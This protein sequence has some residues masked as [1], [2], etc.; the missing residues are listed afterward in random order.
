MFWSRPLL[1]RVPSNERSGIQAGTVYLPPP[2]T[3]LHRPQIA[4][5]PENEEERSKPQ[6]NPQPSTLQPLNPLPKAF[7]PKKI[8]QTSL[9]TPTAPKKK[10]LLHP[11]FRS[12]HTTLPRKPPTPPPPPSPH[13]LSP[14]KGKLSSALADEEVKEIFPPAAGNGFFPRFGRAWSR[15]GTLRWR[16]AVVL[17]CLSE[18]RGRWDGFFLVGFFLFWEKANGG[19]GVGLRMRELD[20]R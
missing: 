16:A 3:S 12:I 20:V 2:H 13:S 18:E 1:A 17:G 11:L 7:P 8:F 10:N 5:Y 6:T 19:V 4:R 14:G 15:C 9:T